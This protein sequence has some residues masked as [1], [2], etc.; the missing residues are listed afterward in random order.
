MTKNQ[1]KNNIVSIKYPEAARQNLLA[2]A[3]PVRANLRLVWELD[4]LG[5][6][7]KGRMIDNILEI[8]R[9]TLQEALEI[10]DK[11]LVPMQ[12]EDIKNRLEKWK[13]LFHK[14]FDSKMDEV[15]MKTNAYEDLLAKMPADCTHYALNTA[16][17]KFKIF[18]AYFELYSLIKEQYEIRLYYQESI[19]NKLLNSS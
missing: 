10:V 12:L 6:R 11:Y 2:F 7:F 4:E 17:R 13:Y 9:P 3:S 16:M 5:F 14:P 18:P 1:P 19:E 15:Q 8:T